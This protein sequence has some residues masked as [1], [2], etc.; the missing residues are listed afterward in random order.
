MPPKQERLVI[1]PRT[2]KFVPRPVQPPR[3][4]TP[5]SPAIGATDV[6]QDFYFD[7][8]TTDW[9]HPAAITRA[10]QSVQ[11]EVDERDRVLMLTTTATDLPASFS[12]RQIMPP[13]FDQ[14]NLNAC[15]SNAVA[16]AVG[17]AIESKT[18]LA[19]AALYYISRV[20][21]DMRDPDSNIGTA[22]RTVCD[23]LT[24]Y[25]ITDESFFPYPTTAGIAPPK[26]VFD[27][28]NHLCTNV[29]YANVPRRLPAIKAAIV[30]KLPVIFS[31]ALHL[32]FRSQVVGT[33]GVVPMPPLNISDR[34]IGAHAMVIVGYD[35]AT[36]RFE[37][38]N[39]WGESWGVGGYCLLPYSYIMSPT[40]TYDF[41]TVSA[42]R[43]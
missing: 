23:S 3:R 25:N 31:L 41:W 16:S 12:L 5:I 6:L 22:T 33:T 8:N 35:D 7:E 39:S 27:P 14:G 18:P 2:G 15:V 38:L 20:F 40:L 10:L 43:A 32:S 36:Q 21:R 30:A 37:C 9:Q 19:R 42:D 29:S 1:D 17:A 13:V 26:A 34:R 4:P 28:A 11:D 24:K